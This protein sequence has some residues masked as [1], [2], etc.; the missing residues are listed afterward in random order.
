MYRAAIQ[1]FKGTGKVRKQKNRKMCPQKEGNKT[2]MDVERMI[3]QRVT[4]L[5]EKWDGENKIDIE[6][7]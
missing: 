7:S 3:E 6:E 1:P 4:T 5:D 2:R